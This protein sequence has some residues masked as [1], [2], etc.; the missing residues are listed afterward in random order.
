[1]I[2]VGLDVSRFNTMIINSMPRNKAEYIQA[3]SRVARKTP[4]IVFTIHNPFWARDVS[5]FEQFREFHEKLYYYVEPISITPFST[6]TIQLFM[7]LFLAT[8]VRHKF[9]NLA[10]NADAR[11]LGAL[12]NGVQPEDV[13]NAVMEYFQNLLDEYQDPSFPN[14][15]KGLFTNEAFLEIQEYIDDAISDW[16][17]KKNASQGTLGFY[18]DWDNNNADS[19]FVSVDAYE[20]EKKASPWVVQ[21]SLRIIPP[22]SVVSIID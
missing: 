2:S 13:K 22:E 6:K 5:H 11:N 4:G 16:L 1:M 3:T 21:S 14:G 20:E 17:N 18:Y 7:P 12:P 9:A 8:F 10:K 15:L 19:L